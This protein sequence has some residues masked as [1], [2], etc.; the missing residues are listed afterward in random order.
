MFFIGTYQTWIHDKKKKMFHLT[1]FLEDILH[2]VHELNG[3]QLW[4]GCIFFLNLVLYIPI[5]LYIYFR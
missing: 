4:Y 3:Y 2:D 1:D 5:C